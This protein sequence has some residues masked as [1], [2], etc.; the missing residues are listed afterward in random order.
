MI[1]SFFGRLL[2]R[3]TL[4][5]W[6]IF[7]LSQPAAGA[8]GHTYIGSFQL[9]GVVFPLPEGEFTLAAI[10]THRGHVIGA[11]VRGAL[12]ATVFLAR[13]DGRKLSDAVIATAVVQ[14]YWDQLVID[15]PCKLENAIFRLDLSE[16]SF[17][18]NCLLVGVIKP[19]SEEA[20]L[21]K[22][23]HRWLAKQGVQIPRDPLFMAWV[24]RFDRFHYAQ[25]QYL[26][27]ATTCGATPPAPSQTGEATK[28]GDEIKRHVDSVVEWGKFAQGWLNETIDGRSPP[29]AL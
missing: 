7:A 16:R 20:T 23:A 12:F 21:V 6:A 18:Q 4:A 28:L 14:L 25:A 5:L 26:F 19:P 1:R 27:N 9:S 8:I 29:T 3:G 13:I 2:G 24:T 17:H 10:T 22:D 15:E 11:P